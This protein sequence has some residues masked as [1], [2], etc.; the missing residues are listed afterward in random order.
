MQ[1]GNM[2][3]KKR[4]YKQYASSCKGDGEVFDEKAARRYVAAF[5]HYLQGW[6]PTQKDSTILDLACGSGRT[7]FL[8]K[9]KGYSNISGMDISAQQVALARQVTN[10]VTEGNVLGFLGKTKN[11]YNLIF[12]QDIIEHLAKNEVFD[13]LDA[14][15]AALSPGGRLILST[16]NA[17]SPMCGTRRWGD[18]THEIGFTPQALSQILDITGFQQVASREMGPYCHGVISGIRT[19]LWKGLRRIVMFYNMVEIGHRGSG[20]YTRD[21]LIS[22]IKPVKEG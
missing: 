3:Y 10:D 20:I 19:I 6:L 9:E 7:L 16:P 18:F 2:D 5:S 21:F 12:A 14:C 22:V 13:I 4:I 8:L 1:I 17:E 15:H 11:K